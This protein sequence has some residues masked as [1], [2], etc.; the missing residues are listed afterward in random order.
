[1]AELGKPCENCG[2][3]VHVIRDVTISITI[4]PLKILVVS[5]DRNVP[6]FI[7]QKMLDVGRRRAGKRKCQHIIIGYC[8][9]PKSALYS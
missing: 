9:C 2:K 3:P 6:D 1:M 8:P 4:R 5:C 7:V